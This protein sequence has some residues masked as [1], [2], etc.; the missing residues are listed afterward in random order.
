MASNHA[1]FDSLIPHNDGLD[2]ED[3]H[4]FIHFLLNDFNKEDQIK[5]MRVVRKKRR[6]LLNILETLIVEVNGSE[7][8]QVESTHHKLSA[9][10]CRKRDTEFQVLCK[11]K[12]TFSM[13]IEVNKRLK[14][15]RNALKK[16]LKAKNGGGRI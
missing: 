10:S 4:T 1:T 9:E 3:M 8:E 11:A 12:Q 13:L 14:K 15:K 6:E 2:D 16:E 5:K 7:H